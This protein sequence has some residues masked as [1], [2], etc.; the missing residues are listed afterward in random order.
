VFRNAGS[1]ESA[2]RPVPDADSNS[3]RPARRFMPP[4]PVATTVTQTWP[5]S[6]GSTVAPK[7]M[8]VSS[9]AV[10]RTTSAASLT[11]TSERSSPPEIERRMPRART[12][13][14]SMS[15]EPSARSAA[16]RARSW[17]VA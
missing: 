13:S 17:P 7:M 8:F 14:A 15:G 16:S 3:G 2:A 10:C 5:V 6:R 11:S 4:R 9:V 12:I 1:S